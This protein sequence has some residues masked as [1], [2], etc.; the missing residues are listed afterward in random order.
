MYSSAAAADKMPKWQSN[1]AAHT[2]MMQRFALQHMHDSPAVLRSASTLA[3]W[4]NLRLGEM[5]PLKKEADA[6]IEAYL[7]IR[8]SVNAEAWLPRRS[9]PG[10]GTIYIMCDSAGLEIH[11]AYYGPVV[12]NRRA[13][14]AA[15]F[16]CAEW[17]T[18]P[19]VQETWD[20][21]MLL[22]ANSTE[23]ELSNMNAAFRYAALTWPDAPAYIPVKDSQASTCLVLK[24]AARN[25]PTLRMLLR[26]TAEIRKLVPRARFMVFWQN[27]DRGWIADLLSK[28]K[29][30]EARAALA[31]RY[32]FQPMEQ[33]PRR[34]APAL[35]NVIWR[36][37]GTILPS[38]YAEPEPSS[39]P[40][41]E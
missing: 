17:P 23:T 33:A 21:K 19:Y 14:G 1:K 34:R 18:I 2:Y 39:S 22:D 4:C 30:T 32:P 28:F 3:E 5:I 27:R 40:G 31:E 11:Q 24:M 9:P 6:D 38:E 41:L 16:Y 26:E 15:W 7:R 13:A 37:H 36:K 29:D 25:S 10:S 35:L 20:H 8:K 12:T